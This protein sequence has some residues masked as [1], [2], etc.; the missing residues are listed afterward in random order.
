MSQA[1][2]TSFSTLPL[3]PATLE[4]LRRLGYHEMT[5]IQAAS[6]PPALLGKD[7]IAQAKTGSGKTAAFALALLAN[8]NTRRFAVQALVLCPTRE[9]ADQVTTEIRRLARAEDNIKVVT[10]SGGVPLRGQTASLE[11]GA[12]IVVGTPGR[13]LDHLG[14][15]TLRVDALNTLVLDEADRMLDMGFV[16]D[17]AKVAGQCP[18]QRQ[19]LLFSATYPEGIAR[20][21]ARFLREPVTVQVE[22]QHGGEQIEQRWY[23]VRESERL[24]AVARLLDH[25]RPA[26][27]LAF[28]NTKARCR[29]LVAL[30]QA[31][32]YSALALHGDLEQRDRDQ[33]LVRFA[34]GSC[35]VLVATD[36]A[37][38]GLDVAGLAAV[39]NVDV[40][41]DREVHVHRIGRTGRAG[42]TGLA[43]N[44][45]SMDEMGAVGFIEQL[46]GRESAWHDL[47][48]L[49]PADGGRMLPAMATI[50]IQAGRK[51]KIRP[52][53]V[54]GALTADLGYAREQV[55]R[56][57]INEFATYVA[58]ARSIGREAV[59]RLNEGRIKGR[60]VKARLLD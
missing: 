40:T 52:G 20:L 11:H 44:L 18:A 15:G 36:V 51:E 2:P 25:F 5:A 14:R 27:T 57:D 1:L 58:V 41:P 13:V 56:I 12:H 53:D 8:L 42:E 50:H 6:L 31:Q 23:Q 21:A 10:L 54:L 48:E 45:A 19:T 9:L 55:G 43:L 47:A 7:L 30:L 39:I 33:V 59:A 49:T 29:E 28:C 38:R 22:A 37:A 16:D 35:S 4:N 17:I 46:Q 26:S 32:G 34:N 3:A 24:P 60:S